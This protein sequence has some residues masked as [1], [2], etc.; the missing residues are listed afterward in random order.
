[1]KEIFNSYVKSRFIPISI[2]IIFTIF[3]LILLL[4]RFWQYEAFYYDHGMMEST[5]YQISRFKLP[6]HDRGFGRV[7]IYIDH[8]YPSLQLVLAP[9]YWISDSYETPIIVMSILIGLSVL[10]GYEIGLK[11]KIN[12]YILYVLLFAYVTYIG[13]QNALIFFV[14]DITLQIPFLM[15][16]FLAIVYNR[17]KLFYLL[18][19]INLGF[20]ES[21]SVTG[22][23]LG[24]SLLLFYQKQ[25]QKHAVM[26]ILI[27]VLY[28]LLASKLIIPY[29][30]YISFGSWG[31]FGYTPDIKFDPLNN[32]L[33]FIDTLQKRETILTSLTNFGF[34]PL[35]SPFSMILLIQDFAQRFVL[36]G[37]NSPLRQG[38]NLHYNANLAVILFVG[39]IFAVSKLQNYKLYRKLIYI[40]ASIILI[41][42]IIFHQFI[43]H[44]PYG[45][46]YNREFYKITQN[47]TFMNDFVAKIPREGKLMI[48]NNLAVRF[49]HDDLYILS[50]EEYLDKVQPDVIALDFR[51]G[52]NINNYWPVTEEKMK[53]LSE[54]LLNDP[55]YKPLYKED[56]RYIFVKNPVS[57]D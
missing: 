38:L 4:N 40:H 5:A 39:S 27:S 11:L 22:L 3:I 18:L 20:K 9:F 16:L 21:F 10:I 29:F 47:M 7:P 17:I 48:Q 53:N 15:L 51:P 2:T 1:M 31:H 26:T 12:K 37:A 23:A 42:A 41:I 45:L 30:Q 6:L 46:L 56:C 33:N 34:L 19:I 24:I 52:Q 25:W 35:F 32:L 50:S 28:G 49:T 55:L 14:H 43:Y 57:E 54:K 44:G 36:V 8:L 13:F